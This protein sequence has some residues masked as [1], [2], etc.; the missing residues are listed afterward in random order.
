MTIAKYPDLA[1]DERNMITMCQSCHRKYHSVY[2]G[3]EG[4]ETF[5]KYIRDY[6]KR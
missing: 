5:A 2:E 4:A 6:G 1:A 3:S